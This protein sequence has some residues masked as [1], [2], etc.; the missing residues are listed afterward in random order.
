MAES[1]GGKGFELLSMVGIQIFLATMVTVTLMTQNKGRVA[2]SEEVLGALTSE[3]I[4]YFIQEEINL[5]K[6]DSIYLFTDG[7]ADQFGGEKGKKFMYKP[8]KKLLISLQSKPMKQQVQI[9]EEAF[10]KWKGDYE[11]IDDV[12]VIG[13]RV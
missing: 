6:G 1:M 11:Q 2:S 12:C 8:L 3:S 5:H 7:F 9:I 10:D 13:V 4:E